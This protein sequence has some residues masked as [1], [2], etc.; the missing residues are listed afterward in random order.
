MVLLKSKS[1]T[2]TLSAP[3]YIPESMSNSWSGISGGDMSV[4]Q[5]TKLSNNELK[6]QNLYEMHESP[7]TSTMSS[8][9]KTGYKRIKSN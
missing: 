8:D 1:I 4:F 9:I 5:I 6:M 3:G 2:Q 7:S